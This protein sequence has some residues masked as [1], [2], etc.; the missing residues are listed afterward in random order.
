MKMGIGDVLFP[1][2]ESDVRREVPGLIH[3]EPHADMTI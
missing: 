2:I 3:L 1:I